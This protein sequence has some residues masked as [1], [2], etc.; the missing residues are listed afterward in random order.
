MDILN[1]QY[2]PKEN[3]LN[4]I[5]YTKVSTNDL[6]TSDSYHEQMIMDKFN[7]YDDNTKQ[8]LLRC[9]IHISIIGS[10]N[11]TYGMIRSIDGE[12][13]LKIEEIFQRYNIVFNKNINEKYDKDTL[14]ARRL[15]RLLRFHIQKF[16]LDTNRPSYLWLKYSDKNKDKISICF[17]GAEHIIDNVDDAKYL[18]DVY[19]NV[20][21]IMNTKFCLRLKRVYIAR[22]IL[23]AE[24]FY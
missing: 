20:D 24:F 2:L 10:G 22:G 1:N 23:P 13:V 6:I 12:T 17:P 4:S 9:A 7:S 19:N 16:I 3:L 8:L 21:K 5:K 18:L 11:K 15:V 14:S